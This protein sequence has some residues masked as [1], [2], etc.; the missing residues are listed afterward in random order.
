M[1]SMS[2]T[3]VL[4]QLAALHFAEIMRRCVQFANTRLHLFSI[5]TD[6]F[7]FCLAKIKNEFL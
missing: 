3:Y 2:V 7:L 6:T 4:L 1:N 5:S